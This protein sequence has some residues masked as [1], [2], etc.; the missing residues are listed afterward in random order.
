MIR[1]H[2]FRG[3]EKWILHFIS[4]LIGVVSQLAPKVDNILKMAVQLDEVC[5]FGLEPNFVSVR[6][7][8]V[9]T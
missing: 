5:N 8:G 9:G 3:H 4:K 7:Y 2:A 6:Q 1:K